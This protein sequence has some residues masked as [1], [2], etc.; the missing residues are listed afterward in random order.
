[1][2]RYW[3]EVSS[4]QSKV[5]ISHRSNNE[6]IFIRACAGPYHS[7]AISQAWWQGMKQAVWTTI[8]EGLLIA[9]AAWG[10]FSF[11]SSS[12]HLIDKW[13]I[14]TTILEEQASPSWLPC[15]RLLSCNLTKQIQLLCL[16]I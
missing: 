16:C 7:L 13:R 12:E 14:A 2:Y 5:N 9:L 6:G 11:G 1:M 3:W 15:L 4:K 10:L 8:G